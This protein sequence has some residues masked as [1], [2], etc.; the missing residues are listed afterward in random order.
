MW[1][2]RRLHSLR[3]EIITAAR[4]VAYED[5][6]VRYED[7]FSKSATEIGGVDTLVY[8]T[9]RRADDSLVSELADTETH[10]IGDCMA[11]RNLMVAI[12]EGHAI[13]NL[14]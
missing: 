3:V 10:L 9:P 14:L 12:H 13:G 2:Q 8:A 7:V 1:P 5:A 6:R 11:P 4:L